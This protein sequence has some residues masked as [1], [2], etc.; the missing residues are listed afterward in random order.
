LKRRFD[1]EQ[2][3]GTH[4]YYGVVEQALWRRRASQGGKENQLALFLQMGTGDGHENPYTRHLGGGVV[5]DAPIPAR[6]GDT[7]GISVSRVHFSDDP[8][9]GFGNKAELA[10][11]TYYKIT[12]VGSLSLVPDLQYFRN[13]DGSSDNYVVF[14]PRIVIAF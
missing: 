3:S 5:M 11:E 4:G 7:A 8:D 14:T 9:C 12:L 6:P 1:G 13:P 10:V 2:T